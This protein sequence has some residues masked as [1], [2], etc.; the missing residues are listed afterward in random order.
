MAVKREGVLQEAAMI[1][2][3]SAKSGARQK[4]I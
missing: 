4:S 2:A 3:V 1:S